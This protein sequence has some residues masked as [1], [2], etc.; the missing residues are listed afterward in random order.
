MVALG[1][2][3]ISFAFENGYNAASMEEVTK[4]VQTNIISKMKDI[5]GTNKKRYHPCLSWY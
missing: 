5:P 2:D 4:R 3:L 1:Q